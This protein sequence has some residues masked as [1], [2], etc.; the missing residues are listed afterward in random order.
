MHPPPNGGRDPTSP[1]G[2]SRHS[3]D[4]KQNSMNRS[5][6][7]NPG[8]SGHPPGT[9]A[10]FKLPPPPL[11]LDQTATVRGKR[12]FTQE[13]AAAVAIIQRAYREH[14]Q[15]DLQ[16]KAALMIQQAYLKK[17]GKELPRRYSTRFRQEFTP[18]EG[19]HWFPRIFT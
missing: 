3:P 18:E 1:S 17:K 12:W 10:H 8:S 16:H 13:E 4:H 14:K 19:C 7:S 5:Y 11:D 6:H 2:M 15:R 9:P